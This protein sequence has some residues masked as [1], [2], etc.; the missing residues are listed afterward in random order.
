MTDSIKQRIRERAGLAATGNLYRGGDFPFPI[1]EA[2][3]VD[4]W[5][6]EEGADAVDEARA[7]SAENAEGITVTRKETREIAGGLS[8]RVAGSMKF[9][10]SRSEVG[11]VFVFDPSRIEP[12]VEPITYTLEWMDDHPGLLARID[13]ISYG[14]VRSEETGDLIGLT[15]EGGGIHKSKRVNLEYT[16]TSDTY[17]SEQ[18]YFAYAPRLDLGDALI[19]GISIVHQQKAVGGS[20]QGALNEYEDYSLGGFGRADSIERMSRAEQAN[21]LAEKLLSENSV[22]RDRGL[23]FNL[24]VVDDDRAW[25]S[26]G[27]IER[28]EF[29]LASNGERTITEPDQLPG[30]IPV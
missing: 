3:E 17:S 5:Y 20:I 18:E 7:T 23:P 30:Y 27:G 10:Q 16:A 13:T 4:V 6:I 22:F 15:W 25:A 1:I 28:S 21:A 9:A 11:V 29:V 26:N 12:R 2:D 8:S 24:V 19:G 14:E